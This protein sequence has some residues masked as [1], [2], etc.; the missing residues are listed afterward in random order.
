MHRAPIKKSTITDTWIGR[1][2]SS[3]YN[4][5]CKQALKW[6]GTKQLR[7][8][9]TT[10]IPVVKGQRS[11]EVPRWHHQLPFQENAPG[12]QWFLGYGRTV[13]KEKPE[14][15]ERIQLCG[16]YEHDWIEKFWEENRYGFSLFRIGFHRDK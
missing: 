2:A 10:W 13:Y 6:N 3:H 1:N 15:Q 5:K 9:Q 8:D 12:I 14:R 16:K 7:C 11:S 4:V